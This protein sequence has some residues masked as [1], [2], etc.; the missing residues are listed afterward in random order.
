MTDQTDQ[1]DHATPSTRLRPGFRA[2]ATP[3][4]TADPRRHGHNPKGR[5]P[6]MPTDT[7]PGFADWLLAQRRPGDPLST[8]ADYVCRRAG[9]RL[10]AT[11]AALAHLLRDTGASPATFAAAGLAVVQYRQAVQAAQLHPT[12]PGASAT[13]ADR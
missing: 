10:P 1:T 3:A 12:N 13:S 6:A 2:S 4:V 5:H 7:A 11:P 9:R 8:L